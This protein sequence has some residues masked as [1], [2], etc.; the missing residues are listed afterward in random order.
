V[1][2]TVSVVVPCYNYGRYL[3]ACVQSVLTETRLDVE[4]LVIDDCSS[5]ETPQVGAR[6]ARDPRVTFR[7]HERN[8]GH[9][10]T[11]NEGL[12]WASGDYTALLSADDLLTPGALFRAVTILDATP[13]AGMA[14]GRV[15]RFHTDPP[16]AHGS[17]WRP[18]VWTGTD[19]VAQRCKTGTNPIASP[20]VLVRTSLYK[21]LGGYRSELP[22][23]GDLEMWLRVAA[24]ADVIYLRGADQACYRVHPLAMSRTVFETSIQDLRGRKACFDNFFDQNG[25]LLDDAKSLRERVDEA[26]AR[27][28]LW[29][30]CRAFDRRRL[31]QVS[32][33]EL[34]SFAKDAYPRATSLREYQGLR[35]RRR[36]GPRLAP[37]VQFALP[38]VY[39]HRA[40]EWLWW[41]RVY[42]T[43]V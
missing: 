30:A 6:V 4:V 37:Q 23:T 36:L 34:E 25:Y 22:H 19:W 1:T 33:D 16:T 32:V 3:E 35:L 40:R 17:E 20:E 39:A 27:E 5:D 14:Y 31:Q 18:H 26:L 15:L 42:G 2:G 29:R 9:I 28:A 12:T 8:I 43:G 11:Y 13:S 41:R 7:R 10:A 21:A 24:H 38:S